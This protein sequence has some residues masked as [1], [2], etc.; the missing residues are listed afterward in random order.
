MT[1]FFAHFLN[2]LPYCAHHLLFP[3]S[4]QTPPRGVP[5]SR[6]PEEFT[7]L[8]PAAAGVCRA[9]LGA[10]VGG[11]AAAGGPA[12]PLRRDVDPAVTEQQQVR[13]Q[14]V[15][16]ALDTPQGRQLRLDCNRENISNE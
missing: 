1:S 9:G 5:G 3:P 11:Q 2:L 16:W 7:K 6:R 8:D 15:I 14:S 10:G 4:S 12:V 13:I